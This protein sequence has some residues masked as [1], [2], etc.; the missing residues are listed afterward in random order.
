MSLDGTLDARSNARL[1]SRCWRE[2]WSGGFAYNTTSP[3]V[4]D[5]SSV[6]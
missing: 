4:S 1:C 3:G 2:K 6:T 5:C